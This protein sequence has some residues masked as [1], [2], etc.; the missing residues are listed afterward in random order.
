MLICKYAVIWR[1]YSV[2]PFLN[3]EHG[4]VSQIPLIRSYLLLSN[5]YAGFSIVFSLI[6]STCEHLWFID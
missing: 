6:V 4:E 5:T 2:N 3:A 1:K